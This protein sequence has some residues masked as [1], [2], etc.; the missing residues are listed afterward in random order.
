MKRQR[1]ITFARIALGALQSLTVLGDQGARIA[2]EEKEVNLEEEVL[3]S[4]KR[5]EKITSKLYWSHA[6][7]CFRIFFFFNVS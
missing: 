5:K 7:F 6:L 4:W 1:I 2:E 3:V